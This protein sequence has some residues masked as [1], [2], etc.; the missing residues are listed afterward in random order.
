MN[1][2]LCMRRWNEVGNIFV[3][4]QLIFSRRYVLVPKTAHKQSL[5]DKVNLFY[6]LDNLPEGEVPKYKC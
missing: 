4:F 6:K 2:V 3:K 1:L 5:Q